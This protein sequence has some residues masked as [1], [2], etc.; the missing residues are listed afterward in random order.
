MIDNSN[1]FRVRSDTVEIFVTGLSHSFTNTH[2]GHVKYDLQQKSADR[3]K[4]ICNEIYEYRKRNNLTLSEYTQ[5]ILDCRLE[6]FYMGSLG[7][8]VAESLNLNPNN[9][10]ILVGVDPK[11]TLLG[12]DYEV[13]LLADVNSCCFYENLIQENIDWE[14]IEVDMP[15]ISL[16]GRPTEYRARFTKELISLCGDRARISLGNVSQL[17]LSDNRRKTYEALM[18]PYSFPFSQGTDG[19]ILGYILF[20]KQIF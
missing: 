3:V 11:G 17:P 12:Y 15:I 7:K 16:A 5:V 2:D 9:T 18:H 1:F 6:N 14:N 4:Y 19:K 8:K 13:D 20:L 10:K